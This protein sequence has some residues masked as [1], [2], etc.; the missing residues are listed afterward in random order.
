MSNGG[1]FLA[2]G[3]TMETLARNLGSRAG[4]II[5]DRTGLAGYYQLTLEYSPPGDASAANAD[6]APSLFTALREQLGLRLQAGRAPVQAL[7]IERIARP[8]TD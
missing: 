4:R 3:I 6:D 8:A 5:I 7:E 2:G 1:E